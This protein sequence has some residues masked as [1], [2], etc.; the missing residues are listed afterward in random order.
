MNATALGSLRGDDVVIFMT[1]VAGL[2]RRPKKSF[3]PDEDVLHPD[4]RRLLKALPDDVPCLLVLNKVDLVRDKSRLLPLMQAFSES[5]PFVAIVPVSVLSGDGVA[6][7]LSEVEKVLPEGDPQFDEETLTDR[8]LTFF[9][10]EYVR[11]QVLVHARG[12]VP[13]AVAVTVER[14]EQKTKLCV[15]SATV[16]VERSGQGS[17]L[18]GKGGQAIKAIGTAARLRLETLIGGK[19]HLE[20]FVRVSERWKD[21]PRRLT[22]LGYDERGRTLESLLPGRDSARPRKA[23]PTRPAKP[24]KHGK[25]AGRAARPSGK[26]APRGRGGS[27]STKANE[28]PRGR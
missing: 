5:H 7:I 14:F 4:D 10:R 12:E 13:H 28:K 9:V 18:V 23:K 16:H 22:E 1:D 2:Q 15:I 19:V 8:P 21:T 3:L 20:L 24:E 27:P 6:R 26:K 25:P 17:I 11:E